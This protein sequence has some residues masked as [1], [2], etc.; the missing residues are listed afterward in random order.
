MS[1]KPVK[2]S[3]EGG[4]SPGNETVHTIAI[5]G[6][7]ENWF[8]DYASYVILERAVPRVEDGFKPVQRRI[9]HALREMDDG[10]FNK[11]ANV[12]GSTMQYHPHGDAAIGEAIINLGQKDILFDTQGNWGDVRTGDSAAAPRYIEVRP[13]RFALDVVYNPQTTEWQL[14][15]DGRK[16]EPVT[17]PVKFPLL[18]AQGVEGIAVGLSTKIL[19]HN[20]VELIKASIDVLKGKNPKIYPDF[21]T[22]GIAD[23][24]EYDQ[25]LR[26]GKIKVRAR[27]E[28]VDKKTLA[29]REIPFGTTTTSLIESIVKASEKGKIK[30]KQVIDN[31]ARD[32]E[33]LIHLQSGQSPEIAMDAL[34]AFTDC[35]IS[36][37]PNACVI[38][39]DKPTF[40]KV[41]DIL[42]VNTESTVALLKRELEIRRGEL[43][44]KILFGSLEKIFIEK[45]IYRSIEE[46][47]TFEGVIETIDKGL[48]PYQKQFYREITRDDILR[49]ME[50]RIKRISK[51]DS[52]KAD[53]L[54]R[55]LDKELKETLHHLRHLTDYAISYF[56]GLLDKY[57]KGRE[58]KTELKSFQSV[59]ATEVIANN[60]KLYV[61]RADGFIG[62]GLKKDE[63]VCECSELDDIIVLRKDGK[64]V[65][66]RISEKV[67][68]GKDILHVGVWR[69]GDERMVYNMI[70]T[71]AKS[72]KGFAKR[73]AMPA[74]I[75]DKEYDLT[76]GHPNNKVHYLS[77]NPN[78]EAEVVEVKLTPA[79]T[80]RKKIFDFDFSE[81]E[82]K[83]RGAR[84]NVIT[85]YPI[86][87]VDFK[88][89]RGTTLGGLELWYDM[90]SGRLN[91]EARGKRLGKFHEDDRII[92]VTRGGHYRITTFE[93]TNRYDPEK[94]IWLEKFNPRKVLTAV[95]LDGDS[96]HHFVKRFTIE[97]TTLDKEFCF[98]SEAVGSRLEYMSSAE[99]PEVE[100]EV[101]KGKGKEKEKEVVNLDDL[102]DVKGWK[103]VGNRLSTHKVT[104]VTS[105]DEA[106][107][108]E[109]TEMEPEATDPDDDRGSKK[110]D[111]PEP[112]IGPDGQTALFQPPPPEN[113]R[114]SP[115][116]LP[117]KSEQGNLFAE[118]PNQKQAE[119]NKVGEDK[120]S[121]SGGERREDGFTPGQTVEWNF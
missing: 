22:G 2:P 76:T 1:K 99:S 114:E 120:S 6:M 69:K 61:N 117:P 51:F 30:V 32:V 20:F 67:F 43:M 18:L 35:E 111:E 28:M 71:D 50:I 42:K 68:V 77:A 116:P 63:L 24:A 26:G 7:Y 102:V 29:I 16:K 84:G 66:S 72:G 87:R 34:Y 13:S 9:M 46:V 104:K 8:L 96:K 14:S 86:R 89:S 27:L 4:S 58:R 70:Y 44:E 49:L 98:I 112:I 31:T 95:Y 88:E 82:I 118:G 12:I 79:S 3:K 54:L 59:A 91:K 10:R 38:V 62:W 33:I 113:R 93:L 74:V 83:G 103:S 15:Y 48:K 85:K 109:G 25:G 19:P 21:P 23:V 47:D 80:A 78:G 60:Q 5:D 65:V 119:Q 55:D 92:A 121:A 37:S 94:V 45:R 17:L 75:R 106:E 110:K 56:Q 39:A 57:G 11:V 40:L 115:K 107:G 101:V 64:A 73:F 90:A 100:I 53:E 41:N 81:L 52:F 97:T 105:L 36:I 108:G